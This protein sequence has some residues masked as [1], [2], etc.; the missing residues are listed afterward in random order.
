MVAGDVAVVAEPDVDVVPRHGLTQRRGREMAVDGAPGSCRRSWRSPPGRVGRPRRPGWRR[1]ARP[2]R[3][4]PLLRSASTRIV[5][6]PAGWLVI[7][8]RAWRPCGSRRGRSGRR[9][10]PRPRRPAGRPRSGAPRGRPR[11]SASTPSSQTRTWTVSASA[12]TSARSSEP[13]R[14]ARIS[15]RNVV[16]GGIFEPTGRT[17]TVTSDRPDR[18]SPTRPAMERRL[19]TR[20]DDLARRPS[21]STARRPSSGLTTVIPSRE[22]SQATW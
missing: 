16:P 11:S 19:A 17:T 13:R 9:R 20:P 1:P 3:G 22:A 18:S 5:G 21:R 8:R 2:R 7:L 14:S 4:R 12:V 6:S 10:P 15:T